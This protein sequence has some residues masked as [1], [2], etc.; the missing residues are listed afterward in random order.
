MAS[1]A[2]ASSPTAR[3][4]LTRVQEPTGLGDEIPHSISP[5]PKLDTREF[6]AAYAKTGTPNL[7]GCF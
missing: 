1:S 7:V 6:M 3:S 2:S 4:S 5:Q